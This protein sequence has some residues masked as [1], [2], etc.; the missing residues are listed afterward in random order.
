MRRSDMGTFTETG[1]IFPNSMQH[2]E[3]YD[4]IHLPD[5]PD[6]PKGI[7]SVLLI[8]IDRLD[9]NGVWLE[10]PATEQEMQ[11]VLKQLDEHFFDN[12]LIKGSI[13]TAFPYPLAGDEDIEKFNV[14]AQ[15]IQAFPDQRTLEKFKAALELEI[16]NEIDFALDIAENLD[17][18][19]LDPKMYSPAAYAEYIFREAGI[20]P[21]DP[22]FAMFAFMG[23][24]ERQMQQAGH[25]QTAY[26]M[27]LHNENPFVS[28]Y[29]QTESMQMGGM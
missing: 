9:E 8:S 19:D 18:Y 16:R 4:G 21:N 12:C 13:S 5:L 29:S 22:A 24:G 28:R 7:I 2:Q 1:Y 10:L 17:C 26:G 20:D 14:L 27:I 23:Y 15:K 11:S 3:L 6:M 25:I